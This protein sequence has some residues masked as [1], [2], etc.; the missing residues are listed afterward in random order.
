MVKKSTKKKN[1]FPNEKEKYMCAKHK[2]FLQRS[3]LIGKET[4]LNQ[5]V[6][7]YAQFF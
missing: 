5:I 4:S 1:T 6:W 7:Q 2:K 3:L